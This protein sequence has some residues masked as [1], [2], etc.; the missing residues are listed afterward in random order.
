VG[1]GFAEAISRLEKDNERKVVRPVHERLNDLQEVVLK[2][3]EN[4]H[5][6]GTDVA[7][8]EPISPEE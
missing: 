5:L 3:A 4:A 8:E 6:H 7:P 1:S 2:M